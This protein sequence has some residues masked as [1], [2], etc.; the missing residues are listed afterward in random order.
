MRILNQTK[1]LHICGTT[2]WM[3]FMFALV[4]QG[5]PLRM[6]QVN[7][8][9]YYSS[10]HFISQLRNFNL[11]KPIF[12]NGSQPHLP[13]IC[14]KERCFLQYTAHKQDCTLFFMEILSLSSKDVYYTNTLEMIIQNKKLSVFYCKMFI[15]DR[16]DKRIASQH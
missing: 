7:V 11:R 13:N 9:G 3:S 10:C 6:I 12:P 5:T 15:K 4:P 1:N 8:E 14:L 2:N 16:N